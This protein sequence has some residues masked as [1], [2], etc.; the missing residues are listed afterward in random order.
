MESS[1]CEFNFIKEV[2]I[3]GYKN[4]WYEFDIVEFFCRYVKSLKKL[5]L[6]M[7]KNIKKR[8][9]GF[10]YVRLDYIRSRFLGVKVEV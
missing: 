1:N 6:F 9:R 4:Y 10:D 3:D 8:V 7:L 2:T 5:K